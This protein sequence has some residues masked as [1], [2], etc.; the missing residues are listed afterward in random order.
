MDQVKKVEEIEGNK[1]KGS[2]YLISTVN[3]NNNNN[4]INNNN[5]QRQI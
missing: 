3:N 1:T 2:S 5:L 4:N